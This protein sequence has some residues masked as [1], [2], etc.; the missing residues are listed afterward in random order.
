MRDIP[1]YEGLYAA[2]SCGKIWSYRSKKFLKLRKTRDGYL[3][4]SLYKNRKE[5]KYLV[6]RLIA[7]TYLDNP[8]NLPQVSHLDET[9]TNNCVNNLTWAST[10]DNCNMP[11]RKQR[12]SKKVFCLETQQIFDSITEAAKAVNINPSNISNCLAGRRKTAGSYHWKLY[13]EK[14]ED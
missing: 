4:A 1:G 10:K 2:T 6:H 14:D 5:K 11:L 12:L 7:S 8:N 3:Y 9:R 13:E